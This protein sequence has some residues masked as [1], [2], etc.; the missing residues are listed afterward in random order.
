MLILAA[1]GPRCYAGFSPVAV[2]ERCS[3]AVLSFSPRWLL[4]SQSRT[5][6]HKG[7]TICGVRA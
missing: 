5:L 6:K 1:L 4:L 2:S 7:F 3:L